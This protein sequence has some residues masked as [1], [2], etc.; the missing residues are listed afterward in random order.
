[1][2]GINIS[3]N[4]NIGN[5]ADLNMLKLTFFKQNVED[6]KNSLLDMV[7]ILFSAFFVLQC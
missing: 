7:F 4:H 2:E 1:M 3:D 5:F 6:F